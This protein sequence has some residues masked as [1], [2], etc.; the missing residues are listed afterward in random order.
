MKKRQMS[1][2][3]DTLRVITPL[4]PNEGDI[5]NEPMNEDAQ[6]SIIENIYKIMGHREDYIN[7]TMDGELSWR[8]VKSYDIDSEDAMERWQHKLYEISTRRCT[9]LPLKCTKRNLGPTNSMGWI[10]WIHSLSRCN[11]FPY[12]TRYTPSIQC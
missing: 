3:I 4:D 6:S 10:W 9:K 12:S 8:S 7:P 11:I 5:Y 2:E 1:F